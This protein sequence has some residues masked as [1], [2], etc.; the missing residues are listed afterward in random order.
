MNNLNV[1]PM[2]GTPL[3]CTDEE[4]RSFILN[5]GLMIQGG[6]KDIPT[7]A[8]TQNQILSRCS[9]DIINVTMDFSSSD[10]PSASIALHPIVGFITTNSRYYFSCKQFERDILSAESNN[11]ISSHLLYIS[12]GGGEAYYLSILSRTLKAC[13]KPIYVFIEGVCGSAAY[14]IAS[15]AKKITAQCFLDQI[16][17]IGSMLAYWDSD[18][19]LEKM[20][21]KKIEAY[22]EM[23]DLKN[24]RERDLA[25]GEPS[26]MIK[27]FLNPIA[28]E[29]IDVVKSNRDKLSKMD[30]A[31]PVLRGEIFNSSKA[32]EYGL[33]DE[34]QE[35][36]PVLTELKE[37]ASTFKAMQ[38]KEALISYLQK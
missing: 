27:E 33:I 12:S 25:K 23:S 11:Q 36:G 31:D 9:S 1:F 34:I 6:K 20:G 19:Y 32:L 17:S 7:Y 21:F 8:E 10:I 29:F 5:S 35:L 38:E 30:D 18:P 13:K 16:G 15:H 4:Y 22:A 37:L 3:L 2:A 26:Q 14:Y 28:I 24:K